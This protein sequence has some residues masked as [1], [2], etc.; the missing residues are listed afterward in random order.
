[1]SRAGRAHRDTPDV[2]GLAEGAAR[3]QL[4]ALGLAVSVEPRPSRDRADGTVAEQT[5]PRGTLVT[6]G[7]TVTLGISSGPPRSVTVPS[8]LGLTADEAARRLQQAGL[9]AD[10]GIAEPPGGTDSRPGRVWK[11]SPAAGTVLDEGQTA[12]VWARRDA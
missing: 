10:I 2:A 4:V 1:M 7:S 9:V 11:Q 8:L 3:S 12:Q 5:P 6:P